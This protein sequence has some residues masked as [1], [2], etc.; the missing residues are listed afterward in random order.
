MPQLK[1]KGVVVI[2][3]STD[4]AASHKKFSDKY[5]LTFPLLADTEKKVVERYGVWR[6][7]TMYGKKVMGLVRSTFILDEEGKIT[8]IFSKV[9]VDGHYEE[10]LG[11]LKDGG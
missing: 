10:V 3:V 8:K 6:E 5:N 2:G 9:K 7:K 11:A 1:R 4:S